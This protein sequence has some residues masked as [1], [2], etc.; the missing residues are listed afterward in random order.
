MKKPSI[1]ASAQFG[2]IA[3]TQA[4]RDATKADWM[5]LSLLSKCREMVRWSNLNCDSLLF[6]KY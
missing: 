1:G 3:T 4:G 6:A 5:G 2:S